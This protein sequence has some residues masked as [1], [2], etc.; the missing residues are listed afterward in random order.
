MN[1]INWIIIVGLVLVTSLANAGPT[2]IKGEISDGQFLKI[3]RERAMVEGL[4]FWSGEITVIKSDRITPFKIDHP[5]GGGGPAE[6]AE[7]QSV[8]ELVKI[9]AQFPTPKPSEKH[10]TVWFAWDTGSGIELY[11]NH[12]L[13]MFETY[14]IGQ[15]KEAGQD[16]Y[17]SST[18]FIGGRGDVD[19]SWLRCSDDAIFERIW[20][21]QGSLKHYLKQLKKLGVVE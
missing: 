1:K 3:C 8:K 7:R 16:W 15:V 12:R 2:R 6:Q 19:T 10:Q 14:L 21:P 20:L 9:C 13:G 17:S 11:L 18:Y 5:E 4:K